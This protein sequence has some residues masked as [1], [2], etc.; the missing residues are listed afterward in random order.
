M[1]TPLIEISVPS[2]YKN[3]QGAPVNL[4]KRMAVATPDMAQAIALIG[5]ALIEVGGRLV[6]SDLYRSYDMQMQS[7]LDYINKKKTAFSP[8]P[9]GSFH[10][11]GRAMDLSLSELKIPLKKFWEVAKKYGAVPIIATPSSSTSEAWH[12]ECRGSHQNVIDYYSAGHGDNFK[13]PYSAGAASAILAAGI[14]V[15]KFGSNQ[16]EAQLQAA[17]IRLGQNIGNID[18]QIGVK[19]RTA[20]QALGVTSTELEA[21]L[22]AVEDL[23]QNAYPAEYR[24]TQDIADLT[25]DALHWEAPEH[26]ALDG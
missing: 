16:K 17:L 26:L 6:L 20:L 3:N 23:I 19:T 11:A 5:K 7:H 10:E 18:G 4:P 2:I 12:F 8:P 24:I 9:G 22:Q 1:K 15:D 14:H 25:E 13:K 21:M